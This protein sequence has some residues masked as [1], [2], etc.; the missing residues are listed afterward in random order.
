M[1]RIFKIKPGERMVALVALLFV[2]A[3]NA[4]VIAHYYAALTPFAD[5]YH[6]LARDV[7]HISG[8]D[9]WSYSVVSRWSGEQFNIYRHPLLA[10]F[11]FIPYLIN[12]LL[13][14]ITGINCAIFVV[15]AIEVW[16]GFYAI[17]FFYRLLCEVVELKA[18]DARIITALFFSFAY[19]MLTVMVPDHF[20]LTLCMMMIVLYVAGRRIKSGRAMNTLQTVVMFFFTAGVS[21]NNGIKIF[22]AALFANGRRFFR[23]RYLLLTVIV[24]SAIIWTVAVIEYQSWAAPQ[25]A[26]AKQKLK[27]RDQQIR[28]SIYRAY[29]DTAATKDPEEIRRGVNKIIKRLAVEK[30]RRNHANPKIG[31][32]MAKTGFMV[33]TDASTDRWRSIVEN[34][35]GESI[36]LHRA[37]LLQDILKDN[38]PMIVPYELAYYYWVELAIALLFA[39]GIWCARRNKFFW[40]VFSWFAFDMAIHIVLGF[41]INEV[42]IMTAQ[43][44][45]IIPIAIAFLAKAANGMWRYGLRAA[46]MLLMAYLLV[47]N[48]S[49]IVDYLT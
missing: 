13:M 15:G 37:N 14:A 34:L 38:R 1:L 43:W 24:P 46:L 27:E 39:A 48:G 18:A 29:A 6:S 16:C 2:V 49:L 12:Q 28:D 3:L 5:D 41:G 17:L 19:I 7:F 26:I 31:D 42:Y 10:V 8:F 9:A 44:A 23:P 30:Y 45:F 33:W 40:L 47:Y 25:E 36:Q 11:M 21:L 32:P 20:N 22:L 4:L 35:F